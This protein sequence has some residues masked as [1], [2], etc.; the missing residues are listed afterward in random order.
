M[1]LFSARAVLRALSFTLSS[2]TISNSTFSYHRTWKR[3]FGIATRK[4]YLCD[5]S[6]DLFLVQRNSAFLVCEFASREAREDTWSAILLA[7]TPPTS[8]KSNGKDMNFGVV[9]ICQRFV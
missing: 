7:P 2:S 4:E 3:V 1:A 8:Q 9:D 6:G 5:V